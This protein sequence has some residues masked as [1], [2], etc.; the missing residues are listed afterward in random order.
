MENGKMVEEGKSEDVFLHPKAPYTRQLI[1]AIPVV[2]RRE[3]AA[4]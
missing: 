2:R 4:R 3:E 1:A